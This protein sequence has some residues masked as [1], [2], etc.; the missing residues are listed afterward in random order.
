MPQKRI[1]CKKCAK[2]SYVLV[3]LH[4]DQTLCPKCGSVVKLGSQHVPKSKSLSNSGS[5]KSAAR[6]SQRE[7]IRESSNSTRLIPEAQANRVRNLLANTKE[8]ILLVQRESDEF[9]FPENYKISFYDIKNSQLHF[10][11]KVRE[12]IV[13]QEESK[14]HVAELHAKKLKLRRES[15]LAGLARSLGNFLNSSINTKE[16]LQKDLEIFNEDIKNLKYRLSVCKKILISLQK[17]V[18]SPAGKKWSFYPAAP[19]SSLQSFRKGE[20]TDKWIKSFLRENVQSRS[21]NQPRSSNF[22]WIEDLDDMA[23]DWGW[24]SWDQFM[25]SRE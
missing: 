10:E 15:D 6:S 11:N 1:K 19:F 3:G 22:E 4:D 9:R 2:G 13:F 17:I 25:E 20:P 12:L 16:N 8:L 24:E 18:V 5:R 23:Q 21:S 14:R 7:K